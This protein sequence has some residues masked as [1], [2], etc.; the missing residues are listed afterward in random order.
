MQIQSDVV[1]PTPLVPELFLVGL[2]TVGLAIGVCI[3]SQLGLPECINTGL[4]TL[5]NRGV[6]AFWQPEL[7]NFA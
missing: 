1:N 6:I 4:L 3:N 5:S 7:P 2:E